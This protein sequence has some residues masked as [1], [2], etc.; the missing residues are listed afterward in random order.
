MKM[1]LMEKRKDDNDIFWQDMLDD[2]VNMAG[3][4]YHGI[5]ACWCDGLKVRDL[6]RCLF[7]SSEFDNC[8]LSDSTW[9]Q[10]ELHNVVFKEC[11]L[12]RVSFDNL[13]AV[14]LR[15]EKCKFSKTTFGK[16]TIDGLTIV[17]CEGSL[18][19]ENAE[20][21]GL[22]I[23]KSDISDSD[24]HLSDI[25]KATFIDTNLERSSFRGADVA[26]CLF[27]RC[28]LSECTFLEAVNINTHSLRPQF[29][30]CAIAPW[31]IIEYSSLHLDLYT[32]E[33]IRRT[34]AKREEYTAQNS[35]TR[36]AHLFCS[37]MK[38]LELSDLN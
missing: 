4:K 8:D 17:D 23:L 18:S 22:V 2:D 35:Y 32:A 26:Q 19:F 25:A 27:R 31:S 11:D 36:E 28:D 1:N 33:T 21:N 3:R 29:I 34:L 16:A 10:G 15:F 12:T 30:D 6:D 38:E 14:H 13:Y 37:D 7:S 9:I 24:F 5:D 20:V